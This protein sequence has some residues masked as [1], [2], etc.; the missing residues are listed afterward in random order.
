MKMKTQ[1][2]KIYGKWVKYLEGNF[3]LLKFSI[4]NLKIYEIYYLRLYTKNW[5][6]GGGK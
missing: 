5:K 2:T 1:H 3:I 4:R 6:G